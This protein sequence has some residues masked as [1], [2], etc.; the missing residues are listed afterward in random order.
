M[1]PRALRLGLV[2]LLVAGIAPTSAEI[3]V[4]LPPPDLS[5]LLPLAALP[6]DKPAVALPALPLPPPPQAVPPLPPPPFV[7]NTAQRPI[8][9]LPPPRFLACNPVGTV[10]GVASELVECG[11][12]RFQRG[13]LE[14][15]RTALQSAIEESTDR[16][17]LRDARYWLGQT[18]LRLGRP[19]D[20][21]RV[22]L[23]VVQDDPRS[24]LG[25][26]A[27]HDVGWLVLARSDSQR[28][29]GYFDGVLKS[30]APPSLA[31]HARHGRA[32]ALYG[33]A[34]Y[35]EA[36]TE[37]SSLLNVGG[38]SAPN[39]PA[40]LVSEANFW[41][42]ET[43]GRLGDYPA[44]VSRL[45]AFTAPNP[46]VL[47]DTGLLRLGWWSRAAGRP[48]DAVKAYRTFLSAYPKSKEVPWARVGLVYALLDLDD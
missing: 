23:L 15:A 13:E 10:L 40:S 17:L 1:R 46:P 44:A 42:G 25:L 47:I 31:V 48:L 3:A 5:V 38:F 4:R 21:E 26:Y 35:A 18:L 2:L 14:E 37:W 9:P 43:L 34:R 6:L 19:T 45:E 27:A 28:A 39:A 11:R 22:L 36:R 16:R 8:A 12:A 30:G 29:L 7:T 32:V 41:L 33:L 20:V 24:E